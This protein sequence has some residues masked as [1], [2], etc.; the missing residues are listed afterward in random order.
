MENTIKIWK[1][2]LQGLVEELNGPVYL[3]ATQTR[4]QTIVEGQNALP[5]VVFSVA[6]AGFNA[7]AWWN[8]GSN[9]SRWLLIS[10]AK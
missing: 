2:N 10:K 4:S 8:F 9:R 1:S 7:E 3:T 6:V 5:T